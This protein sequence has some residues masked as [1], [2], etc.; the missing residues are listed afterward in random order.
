MKR[1]LDV[2]PE[3]CETVS[4]RLLE[5]LIYQ[6]LR[7][8]I[9]LYELGTFRE[10]LSSTIE[11]ALARQHRPTQDRGDLTMRFL[12]RAWDRLGEEVLSELAHRTFLDAERGSPPATFRRP[13]DD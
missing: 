3:D 4:D 1:I 12:N 10:E 9:D 7:M 6:R 13:R 11:R 5:E 2:I 8:S